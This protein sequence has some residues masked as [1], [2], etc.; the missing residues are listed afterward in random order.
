VAQN[1]TKRIWGGVMPGQAAGVGPFPRVVFAPHGPGQD[2]GFP[3][4]ASSDTAQ[5]GQCNQCSQWFF[6]ISHGNSD[7]VSFLPWRIMADH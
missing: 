3:R 7:R 6:T 4:L 2:P 1:A 5:A